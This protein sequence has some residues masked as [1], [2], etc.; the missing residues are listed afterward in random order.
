VRL[1][2]RYLT[3]FSGSVVSHVDQIH[4]RG[5]QKDGTTGSIRWL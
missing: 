1:P 2:E 4:G 5:D 3:L